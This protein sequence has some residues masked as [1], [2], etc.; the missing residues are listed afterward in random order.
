VNELEKERQSRIAED[1]RRAAERAAKEKA[2]KDAKEA[3]LK[4]ELENRKHQEPL[5]VE[6]STA[7]FNNN[8]KQSA[9]VMTLAPENERKAAINGNTKLIKKSDP[10][11]KGFYGFVDQEKPNHWIIEP[12]Y[13]A[14]RVAT[15]F[16]GDFALILKTER[17]Y[18][19]T[20]QK[21]NGC[22][23]RWIS[24]P[25]DE[26]YSVI[27][28]KEELVINESEGGESFY[29]IPDVPF[30]IRRQICEEPYTDELESL[31]ANIYDL[32]K[33]VKVADLAKN[34]TSAS[35][36]CDAP[37]VM[38]YTWPTYHFNI[39]LIDKKNLESTVLKRLS[40]KFNFYSEKKA[41]SICI[42]GIKSAI[43]SA[44]FT[45]LLV[46]REVAYKAGTEIGYLMGPN[47]EFK[48]IREP[49]LK[50]LFVEHDRW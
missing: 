14:S 12:K 28:R 16:F 48:I 39:F 50:D 24:P 43:A 18:S 7:G 36:N 38:L 10:N 25:L 5:Q 33:K 46:Y 22:I 49:W 8:N 9:G 45:H 44:N 32:S 19:K 29:F 17:D 26:Y 6:I 1:K 21:W 4:A 47:S 34:C 30:V 40:L 15:D 27:N 41:S 23:D 37:W 35:A 31:S 42:E 3:A 2:E 13:Q 11:R 20:R